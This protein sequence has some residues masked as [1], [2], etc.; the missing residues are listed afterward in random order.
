MLDVD[1]RIDVDPRVEQLVHVLPALQVP[2]ALHVRMRELVDEDQL[3]RACERGVE[4]EFGQRA[5]AIVDARE[6]QHVEAVEQRGGFAAAVRLDDADHDVDAVLPA[7]ARGLQHRVGLADAG[8]RAEEDLEPAA[9]LLFLVALQLVEQLI[10]I[11]AVHAGGRRSARER[12]SEGIVGPNR[13]KR[14]RRRARRRKTRI[15]RGTCRTGRHVPRRML[16]VRPAPRRARGSASARSRAAR[17]ARRTGAPSC[18]RRRAARPRRA[19]ACA[20]SRRARPGRRRR[21]A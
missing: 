9:P 15:R 12:A 10:G 18:S 2:R 6:R 17:R 16:S 11:G 14:Q 7:L 19:P 3:R 20:P 13:R 21:P 4:I 1:G 8:R 5:A